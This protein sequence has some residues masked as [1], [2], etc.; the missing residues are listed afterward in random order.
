MET[1]TATQRGAV[2]HRKE[3]SLSRERALAT[4]DQ[5]KGRGGTISTRA[6][7]TG[8]QEL[9]PVKEASLWEN[10]LLIT[11]HGGT[12]NLQFIFTET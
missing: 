1:R 10:R 12:N 5:G 2:P 9:V 7:A 4:L 6:V 11:S 3:E 8:H